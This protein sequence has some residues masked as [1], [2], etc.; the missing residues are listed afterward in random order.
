MILNYDDRTRYI[1]ILVLVV[2]EKNNTYYT[3]S[4]FNLKS[5]LTN[6]FTCIQNISEYFDIKN[7]YYPAS[8]CDR[9]YRKTVEGL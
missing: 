4:C 7:G 2:K 5:L 9:E 6:I 3:L 8:V 1:Y